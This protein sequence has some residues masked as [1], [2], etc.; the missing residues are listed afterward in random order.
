M[1]RDNKNLLFALFVISS[2]MLGPTGLKQ[3][4]SKRRKCFGHSFADLCVYT[5]VVY[6]WEIKEMGSGE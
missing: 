3:K 2:Q 6:K 1:D 5:I 4:K